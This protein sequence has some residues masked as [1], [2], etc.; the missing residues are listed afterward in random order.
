MSGSFLNTAKL[1]ASPALFD[2]EGFLRDLSVWTPTLANDIAHSLD[3]S[4]S[5]RHYVVINSARAFYK[6]YQRMPTT[7]VF[8]KHLGLSLGPEFASSAALMQLFPNTPMRLLA[9]CAGLPKPPNCF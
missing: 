6:D 3:L 9:L 2:N 5:S 1:T 7:R 4:L 8:V